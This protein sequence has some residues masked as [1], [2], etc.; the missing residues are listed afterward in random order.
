MRARIAA[1]RLGTEDHLLGPTFR[2][3]VEPVNIGAELET[4]SS[5]WAILQPQRG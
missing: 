2:W 4:D 5:R 1:I 3:E